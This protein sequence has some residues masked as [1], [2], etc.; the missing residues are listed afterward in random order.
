MS[1]PQSPP[2]PVREVIAILRAKYPLGVICGMCGVLVAT[3]PASY[4]G[5]RLSEAERQAFTCGECRQEAAEAERLADVRRANLLLARDKRAAQASPKVETRP[6]I[7]GMRAPLREPAIYAG[8][9]GGFSLQSSRRWA[10]WGR[11]GGRPRKYRTEQ[12]ARRG[13]TAR[14]RAHRERHSARKAAVRLSGA[15]SAV[16]EG[17]LNG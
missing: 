2:L 7:H 4:A 1:I 8:A 11:K 16:V 10:E 13:A 15:S 9:R 6:S 3:Q 14:V 12:D 5:S 17:F